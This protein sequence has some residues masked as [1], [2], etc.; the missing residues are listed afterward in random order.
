MT[1]LAV[2]RIKLFSTRS[3][4][5][6][7]ATALALTIGFAAMMG[8]AVDG[9]MSLSQAL[10]GY[11]FGLMVVLVLA[12]LAVTTEYRFGTIRATFQA[13]PN[14]TAVLLAKAGVVAALA[15]VLGELAAFGSWGVAQLLAPGPELAVSTATEWRQLVGIGPLFALAAVLAVGVGALLRQTAGAVTLLIIWSLLVEQLILL[16]PNIG[17]DLQEWMPFTVGARFLQSD[18]MGG[19]P[20]LGPW[21]S[22][23]YFAAVAF[24]VLA[25]AAVVVHRRDA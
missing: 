21:G 3:P 11:Q 1:L 6:C 24:A 15:F 9:G 19:D 13:A 22:L 20:P 10:S 18:L 17:P 7:S 23:A 12:A 16:V 5:W 25:T 2:E 8:W 4:W 14:R